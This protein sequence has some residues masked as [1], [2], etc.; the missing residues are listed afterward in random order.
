MKTEKE[1]RDAIDTLRE[2]IQLDYAFANTYGAPK[3]VAEFVRA[4]CECMK[5]NIERLLTLCD[6]LEAL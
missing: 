5:E 3:R 4:S 6:E 1:I 2:E